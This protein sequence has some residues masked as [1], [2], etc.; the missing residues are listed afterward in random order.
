MDGL[1]SRTM[2]ELILHAHVFM[3]FVVL[4]LPQ[5]ISL[6][7]VDEKCLFHVISTNRPC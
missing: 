3:L 6:A 4:L 2:F 5:H 7:V 1:V